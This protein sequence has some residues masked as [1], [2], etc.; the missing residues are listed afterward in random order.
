M[1]KHTVDGGMRG[2]KRSSEPK[3]TGLPEKT[4]GHVQK[5]DDDKWGPPTYKVTQVVRGN[6][7]VRRWRKKENK[8]EGESLHERFLHFEIDVL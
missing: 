3:I 2:A 1:G 4:E 8:E 5:S 6:D 7:D